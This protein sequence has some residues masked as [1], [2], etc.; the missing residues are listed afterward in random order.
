MA[1]AVLGPMEAK[2]TLPSSGSGVRQ[3]MD[4]QQPLI[5]FL[6][7]SYVPCTLDP[8]NTKTISLDLCSHIAHGLMK[9]AQ[10]L[11]KKF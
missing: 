4:K 2:N 6:S 9:C 7:S 3:H 10:I 1:K 5:H 11:K 8:Q